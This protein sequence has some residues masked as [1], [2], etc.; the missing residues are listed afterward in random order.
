MEFSRKQA[1]GIPCVSEDVVAIMQSGRGED[2]TESRQLKPGAGYTESD[3]GDKH[4]QKFW[5]T[6]CSL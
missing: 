2:L 3:F 5:G 6:L 4:S 1:S